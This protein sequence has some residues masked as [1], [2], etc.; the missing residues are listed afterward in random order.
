MDF[1]FAVILGVLGFERNAAINAP[2]NSKCYIECYIQLL[3]IV[4]TNRLFIS[5]SKAV[6]K[7]SG[8]T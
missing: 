5:S 4:E 3:K 7:Q 8:S 1:D 6:A 2:I